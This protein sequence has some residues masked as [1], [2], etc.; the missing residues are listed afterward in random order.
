MILGSGDLST[1]L[2]II[3]AVG[4][5]V[6]DAGLFTDSLSLLVIISMISSHP[7]HFSTPLTSPTQ[8]CVRLRTDTTYLL[9]VGAML[10]RHWANIGLICSVYWVVKKIVVE[11]I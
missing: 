7:A 10:G 9:N 5:S 4:Q 3:L 2:F 11:N 1:R 6:F 8:S